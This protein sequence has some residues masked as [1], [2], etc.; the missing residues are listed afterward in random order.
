MTRYVA[1]LREIGKG[2]EEKRREGKGREG[3]ERKGKERKGKERKG[4]ERFLDTLRL[5][6]DLQQSQCFSASH[7]GH[8]FSDVEVDYP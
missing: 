6:L 3:K 7:Y 8:V 4:K 1:I 2:R 5:K